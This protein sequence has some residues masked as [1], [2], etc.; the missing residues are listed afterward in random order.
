M[1]LTNQLR[2]NVVGVQQGVVVS[3]DNFFTRAAAQI[4]V[5]AS[6]RKARKLRRV[7]AKV[8]RPVV[9]QHVQ[10]Q[11]LRALGGF[12]AC[13]QAVQQGGVQAAAVS[14]KLSQAKGLGVVVWQAVANAF[15][16]R[17]VVAPV[18]GHACSGQHMQQ[19][20][21]APNIGL[22]VV[23]PAH[24]RKHARHRHLGVGAATGD[25]WEIDQAWGRWLWGSLRGEVCSKGGQL[26]GGLP[27]IAVQAPIG[28]ACGFAHHHHQQLGFGISCCCA[29]ASVQPDTLAR[30][31]CAAQALCGNAADRPGQ[32]G[33]C[34]Q[35]ADF[36]VVT[37]QRR[38]RL[39]HGQHCTNG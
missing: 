25:I 16:A 14:A 18:H 23:A 39:K 35:V 8:R 1:Q 33:G 10:H 20:L 5:L 22:V 34:D 11:D 24:W 36:L 30:L 12:K 9:A 7:A 19:R 31:A 3:I 13:R 28:C 2:Q 17:L 37:H 32:V 29:A 27:R 26:R 4:V 21:A 6:W 38:K 15:A